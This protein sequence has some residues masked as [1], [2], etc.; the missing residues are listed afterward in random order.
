MIDLH[1]RWMILADMPEV[2]AIERASFD[3]PWREDDFARALRQRHIIGRVVERDEQ[4]IG[5][6][7]YE[8]HR[9]RLHLLNIGVAP[10]CRRRGV[11]RAMIEL[12]QGK[13]SER[14]SR[15][16]LEVCETNLD[17]QLFFRS[18]GFRAISVL[19]DLYEDTTADAY[20]MRYRQPVSTPAK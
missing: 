2:L 1:I 11:G 9:N 7:I 3:D 13:L 10:D 14:R 6:M 20:L 8:L 4:I 17:A 15:I 5:Y 12:L 19:H 18:L 16:M